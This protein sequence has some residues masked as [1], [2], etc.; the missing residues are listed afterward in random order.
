MLSYSRA[1]TMGATYACPQVTYIFLCFPQPSRRN[2]FEFV[3]T[4]DELHRASY[5]SL[6]ELGAVSVLGKSQCSWAV[7]GFIAQPCQGGVL[8]RGRHNPC[9]WCHCHIPGS[10]MSRNQ[11]IHLPL[12]P[13]AL[14]LPGLRASQ[15]PQ[16]LLLWRGT[17]A[18]FEKKPRK[19]E[20]WGEKSWWGT[21]P[22]MKLKCSLYLWKI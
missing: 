14:N 6:G 3:E 21:K 1:S 9:S 22:A 16:P 20:C 15:V 12:V 13:A 18:D 8:G 7:S 17:V 11:N 10:P 5:V 19:T 4:R 2:P